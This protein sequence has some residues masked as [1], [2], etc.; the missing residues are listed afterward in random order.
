MWSITLDDTYQWKTSN[1]GLPSYADGDCNNLTASDMENYPACKAC[2][3]LEYAGFEEGWQLPSQGTG[4]L[5]SARDG[6]YCAPGRE[7][8]NLGY[9]TCS[10]DP[11]QCS[12]V[13]DS[14]Q[15]SYDPD[16]VAA[17]YWS[18]IEY[19]GTNAWHVL[20]NIGNVHN[21]NKTNSIVFGQ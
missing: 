17:G 14:C 7:L 11:S 20:F 8:W 15:P 19:T 4:S 5:A 2:Y 10:W 21:A 3:D 6:T 9:E 13:Q 1:T 12:E 18:S 16:A